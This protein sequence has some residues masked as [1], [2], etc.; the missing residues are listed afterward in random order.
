MQSVLARLGICTAV[1][2]T[3]PFEIQ[4]PSQSSPPS[5][6]VAEFRQ[7]DFAG[8]WD[9][10]M[11]GDNPISGVTGAVDMGVVE[12]NAQGQ[13]L[14]AQGGVAGLFQM[15]TLQFTDS[16]TGEFRA[17][18]NRPLLEAVTF[19]FGWMDHSKRTFEIEFPINNG[20]VTAFKRI[21]SRHS[22]CGT[23]DCSSCEDDVC[24]ASEP[25]ELAV[26][27]DLNELPAVEEADEEA[28]KTVSSAAQRS[29]A[30]TS[31]VTIVNYHSTTVYYSFRW[32]SGSWTSYS[33]SPNYQRTH[34]GSGTPYV[35]FDWSFTSGYQGKTYWLTSGSKNVFKRLANGSGIDLY[36][37]TGSGGGSSGGGGGGTGGSGG[38]SSGGS[39]PSSATWTSMQ[40][41]NAAGIQQY[42]NQASYM[43]SIGIPANSS[44]YYNLGSSLRTM[45]NSMIDWANSK[46]STACN[47]EY[48]AYKS[49]IQT[50]LNA[51]NYAWGRYN[52]SY[53]ALRSWAH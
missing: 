35:A 9:L 31:S 4:C 17:F 53:P 49:T 11:T 16:S 47:P 18:I 23:D 38:G 40:S 45:A 33:L 20:Y 46:W 1:L 27:E 41:N 2:T 6:P 34:S 25:P 15:G 36:R 26:E 21:D 12:I 3:I 22:A 51:W 14:S 43:R 37:V 52:P 42:I 13:V 44:N 28:S 50:K 48:Q 7:S 5:P 19:G 30:A 24:D 39:C 29:A 10:E 8:V 32:G